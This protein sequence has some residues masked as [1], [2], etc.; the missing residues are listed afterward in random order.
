MRRDLWKRN[1]SFAMAVLMA[2]GSLTAVAEM[3]RRL[4]QVERL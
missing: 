4:P 1:V 2:V 3:T